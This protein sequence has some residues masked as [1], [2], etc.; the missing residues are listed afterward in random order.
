MYIATRID[1]GALIVIDVEIS[2]E[3]DAVE[4]RLHVGERVDGDADLADLARGHRVV[5]VV[6]GLR[7]EIERGGEAGLAVLDQV[8]EALV[9]LA[10]SAEAG[11][12]AH[13]PEA[14]AVHRRLHA[15]G[16]RVL[17]GEADVLQVVDARDVR[18]GCRGARPLRRRPRTTCGARGSARAPCAACGPPTRG[19]RRRSPPERRSARRTRWRRRRSHGRSRRSAC[20]SC[21]NSVRWRARRRPCGTRVVGAQ[22]GASTITSASPR[23]TSVPSCLVTSVSSDS[24]LRSVSARVTVTV[25]VTVS[26][27]MTGARNCR[28]CAM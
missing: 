3:R 17:A 22:R 21:G 4:Q 2:I 26:P 9:G 19:G 25:A 5:G 1:A 7:R 6:A 13:G 8:L 10:R 16:E 14:T 23:M 18:A 28:F 27:A 20:S 15:A 12:L 11:V 24:R